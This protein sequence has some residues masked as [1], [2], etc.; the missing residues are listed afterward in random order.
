[1]LIA[2][3]VWF[4]TPESF[5]GYSLEKQSPAKPTASV[6]VRLSKPVRFPVVLVYGDANAV[7]VNDSHVKVQHDD[8]SC[9]QANGEEA[10]E[11]E[12]GEA[13]HQICPQLNV[14]TSALTIVA[15]NVAEVFESAPS[16]TSASAGVVR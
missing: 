3:P 8:P 4:S 1:M 5:H 13:E 12:R 14:T 9:D 15:K 11:K 2:T 16:C 6:G 10:P 7:L